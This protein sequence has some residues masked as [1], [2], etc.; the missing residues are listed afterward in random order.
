LN[1]SGRFAKRQ[2]F[3]KYDVALVNVEPDRMAGKPIE[4]YVVT[5]RVEARP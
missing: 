4:K 5:L 3:G 2:P 1:T